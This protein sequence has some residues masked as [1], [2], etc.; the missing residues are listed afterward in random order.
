M[1]R[2]FLD[3]DVILDVLGNREPHYIYSRKVLNRVAAGKF[4][5]F[6]SALSFSN[7]H[8]ILRK[9]TNNQTAVK[10]LRKLADLLEILN[11]DGTTIQKA[12]GSEFKDFED[13]IQ[14]QVAVL[15]KIDFFITRNVKDYRKAKI[16]VM[17]P[18]EFI[19]ADDIAADIR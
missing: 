6:V 10:T 4:S 16:P 1:K 8:Y 2:L 7:L 5:G 11:V 15:G 19:I 17:T 12:L 18:E 13:A 14:Y 3:T 9:E